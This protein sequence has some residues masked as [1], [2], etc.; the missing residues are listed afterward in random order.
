MP[1]DTARTVGA[2]ALATIAAATGPGFAATSDAPRVAALRDLTWRAWVVEAQTPAAH[3]ETVN[4]MRLGSPAIAAQPD[5]ISVGGPGL[6]DLIARGV[7]TREGFAA[8]GAPGYVAMFDR[9]RPMLAATNAFAWLSGPDTRAGALAAGAQW[10]RLNL[11]VTGEGLALHPVSQALQEYPEMAASFG[12]GASPHPVRFGAGA[13]AWPPG[14][15][16]AGCAAAAPHPALARGI[17]YPGCVSTAPP[18]DPLIFALL[19]EVGIIEQLARNRFDAAQADGLL[20][21]H[22]ILLN[23]LAR[24][25]DGTTPGAHRAGAATGQ[26]RGDQHHAAA[27]GARADPPR[28]RPRGWSRQARVPHPGRARAARGRG[29]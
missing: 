17:A 4:L 23:H 11:A 27:G 7:L 10:L 6:D 8:P 28:A 12:G 24:V 5:G 9:Y 22:F 26:G 14:P 19:N 29:A 13:D 21:S 20:L 3:I 1:F 15:P 16:A 18:D 2:D 25:G